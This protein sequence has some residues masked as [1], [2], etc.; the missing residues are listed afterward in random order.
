MGEVIGLVSIG[1]LLEGFGGLSREASSWKAILS[2]EDY[3]DYR[4]TCG[5]YA[6]CL[7]GPRSRMYM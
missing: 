1:Q 4:P 2:W 7:L 5:L 3:H 6:I